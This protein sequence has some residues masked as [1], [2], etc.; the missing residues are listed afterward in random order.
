MGQ[1]TFSLQNFKGP[2][3]FLRA[4]GPRAHLFQPLPV[5]K[6]SMP[7]IVHVAMSSIIIS[8]QFFKLFS[9]FPSLIFH[10]HISN[11]FKQACRYRSSG[12]LILQSD[13]INCEH[14]DANLSALT[15]A[16]F[17]TTGIKKQIYKLQAVF[18][19]LV[20]CLPCLPKTTKTCPRQPKIMLFLS[21]WPPNISTTESHFFSK[22]ACSNLTQL[23]MIRYESNS[24]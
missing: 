20:V 9:F 10:C 14:H 24:S 2:H 19:I 1:C 6:T 18:E 22:L 7:I 8:I 15:S 12:S 11:E 3:Q 4:I 17:T 16:T 21:S 13:D 5:D 23:I